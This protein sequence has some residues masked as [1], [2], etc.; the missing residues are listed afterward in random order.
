VASATEAPVSRTAAPAS[1][2]RILLR[3]TVITRAAR[4]GR[5]ASRRT[6]AA[7]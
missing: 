3:A 4:G 1:T 5:S 6:A 7:G 2:A